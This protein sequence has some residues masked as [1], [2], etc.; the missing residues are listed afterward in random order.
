MEKAWIYKRKDIDAIYQS[1]IIKYMSKGYKIIT[2]NCSGTQGEKSKIDFTDGKDIYRI[3]YDEDNEQIKWINADSTHRNEY[4]DIIRLS[5]RKY[6]MKDK[7][8]YTDDTLGNTLWFQ[9]GE[10][11]EEKTFYVI[12]KFFKGWRTPSEKLA[13]TTSVDFVTKIFDKCWNRYNPSET[14]HKIY[15][16][17]SDKK[18][19]IEM[20]NKRH[21]G[22]STLRI[23]HIDSIERVYDTRFANGKNQYVVN[24][25]KDW[26]M[27]NKS[28]YCNL[29][30]KN[31]IAKS[32]KNY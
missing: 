9:E 31:L 3:W 17:N 4:F 1:L 13:Y 14:R 25:T 7:S 2:T 24:F 11:I 23:K 18:R 12:N 10:I 26:Y 30:L 22:F 8:L 6:N 32:G 5:V 21:K 15:L 28:H 27:D 29:T 19:I 16:T 20:I